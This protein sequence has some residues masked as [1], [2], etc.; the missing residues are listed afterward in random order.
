MRRRG[1]TL[2]QKREEA[3]QRASAWYAKNG[4]RARVRWNSRPKDDPSRERDRKRIRAW[5]AA[6]AERK[7]A[8]DAELYQY[9]RAARLEQVRQYR[10]NN[11]D[12]VRAQV[13][14]SHAARS[15]RTPRWITRSDRVQ[16][17]ALYKE[18]ARR[19]RETGEAWHVDH[20]IPLR[21]RTV[22]GLHVPNNLQLLKAEENMKKKNRFC[23]ELA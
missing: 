15:K 21:G 18:A 7:R 16:M 13:A 1:I 20:I 14:E 22:S 9:N 10:L 6:N 23:E 11:P 12:K 17:R 19:T 5:S 2:E 3:R 4:E 8:K